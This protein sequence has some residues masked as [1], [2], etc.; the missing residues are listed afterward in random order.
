M[1]LQIQIRLNRVK[2]KGMFSRAF[3]LKNLNILTFWG[4]E[5]ILV[6]NWDRRTSDLY[7]ENK[8]FQKEQFTKQPKG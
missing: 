8:C 6:Y 2:S 1:E 5:A 4:V 7:I 3:S